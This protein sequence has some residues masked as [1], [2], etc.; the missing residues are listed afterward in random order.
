MIENGID[1][2]ALLNKATSPDTK[3]D[4]NYHIGIAGRLTPVKRI[5]LFIDS[6]LLLKQHQPEL[7]IHFHIYGG[8]PLQDTL[9]TQVN[10]NQADDYIHFEGHTENIPQKLQ[11]LDALLMTSD[12]E[13]LPMIL[14]EAM[15]MKTPI[16]AHAVGGIP[17]LLNNGQCGTLIYKHDAAT[18]ADAIFRLIT[19][20]LQ[21]Q[22]CAEQAF[23]RLQKYYSATTNADAY[24][25]T[26][27]QLIS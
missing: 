17:N 27:R 12:H 24:L 21:H 9:V 6:A 14:L 23:M 13:G 19:Q 25:K 11:T 22:Q 2:D 18:F 16:I 8:G 10:V 20:P 1:I 3:G 26:Y 5:D 7:D 4:G 15:C